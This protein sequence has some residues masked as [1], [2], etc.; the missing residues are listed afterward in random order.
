MMT[1]QSNTHERGRRQIE[2]GNSRPVEPGLSRRAMITGMGT[3]LTTAALGAAVVPAL[4]Q[5]AAVVDPETD[6]LVGLPLA[7]V[8]IDRAVQAM[9]PVMGRW[10]VK[11]Y[12][13]QPDQYWGFRQE[14]KV[15]AAER[16]SLALAE[17]KAAYEAVHSDVTGWIDTPAGFSIPQHAPHLVRWTGDGR[18]IVQ[19]ADRQPSYWI[20]REPRY[21]DG[22]ERWFRIST[23]FKGPN[24]RPDFC[25]P[26]HNLPTIIRKTQNGARA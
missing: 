13:G 10:S 11:I 19:E 6:G 24:E 26:E 18:Y 14:T 16:L 23:G 3:A 17:F 20:T 22:P 1:D 8:H 25:C 9:A 15:S 7:A 12:S 2:P 21:D 4:A 5:E